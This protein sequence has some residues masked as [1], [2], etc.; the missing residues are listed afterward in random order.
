M[1]ADLKFACLSCT[2]YMLKM[3]YCNYIQTFFGI[4]VVVYSFFE[5]CTHSTVET[6]MSS[7]KY[8]YSM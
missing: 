5:R 1:K 3:M 4:H 6:V 2:F 8:N 7:L